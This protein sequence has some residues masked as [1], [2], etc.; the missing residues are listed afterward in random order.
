MWPNPQKTEDLVAFTEEI[1]MENFIFLQWTPI[2]AGIIISVY[3]N[4]WTN[5]NL[6]ISMH[7]FLCFSH[8][9]DAQF[10]NCFVYLIH[11]Q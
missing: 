10:V 7:L 1:L 9:A 8:L 3:N 4:I 11:S 2:W 5:L 6:S